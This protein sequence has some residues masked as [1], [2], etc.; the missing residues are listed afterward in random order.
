MRANTLPHNVPFSSEKVNRVVATIQERDVIVDEKNDQPLIPKTYDDGFGKETLDDPAFRPDWPLAE[1]IY[2]QDEAIEVT[3]VGF[4]KG[5]LLTNWGGL[6]GFLPASQ[7]EDFPECHLISKRLEIFSTL[8]DQDVTVKIIELDQGTNRLIFSERAASITADDRSRVLSRIKPGDNLNGRVTNLAAFGVF[9]DLG[10]VEG[11]IHISELSWGRVVHPGDVL[12]PG[13][14]VAVVVLQIEPE[15]ER[16][17]LS[18]K[19]LLPNPWQAVEE[20]YQPGQIVQG[21]ITNIAKF[22]AFAEVEEGLEG[23]IHVS[24]ISEQHFSSPHEV[25][26]KGE[27]VLAR[28]LQVDGGKRRLALSLRTVVGGE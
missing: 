10:G 8:V 11:L 13:Q 16:I 3:I 21:V 9:V 1:Q 7:L 6:P 25:L 17:A 5:G 27:Q 23:L 4:N 19:R 14:E 26:E 18:R 20:R 24:E 15:M 28:V 22:G 12:K 2:K